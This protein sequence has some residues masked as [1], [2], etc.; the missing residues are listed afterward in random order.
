MM[1][2]D[3]PTQVSVYTDLIKKSRKPLIHAGLP[4]PERRSLSRFCIA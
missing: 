1:I 2:L 4:L 3:Q